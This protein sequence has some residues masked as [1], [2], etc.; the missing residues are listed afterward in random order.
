M[1]LTDK[2]LC[3]SDL[4]YVSNLILRT[5]LLILHGAAG[6]R[7][8]DASEVRLPITAKALSGPVLRVVIRDPSYCDLMKDERSLR[9][10]Y[11]AWSLLLS[12]SVCCRQL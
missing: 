6:K 3:S 10:C 8:A 4:G 1:Y 5:L 7:N 12:C 9:A 2:S 11:F